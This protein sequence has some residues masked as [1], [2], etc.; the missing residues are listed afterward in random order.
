MPISMNDV[1]NFNK[2][3][4]ASSSNAEGTPL[5]ISAA[6]GHLEC[7]KVLL[8]NG[9]SYTEKDKND[10]TLVFIAAAEGRD[11]YLDQILMRPQARLLINLKDLHNNTACH[12][13]ESERFTGMFH[14]IQTPH[15]AYSNLMFSLLSSCSTRSC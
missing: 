7:S 12:I 5:L 9:A 1:I 11:K 6:A 10:R 2:R 15:A 8:D 4:K 3:S 13:G 14:K